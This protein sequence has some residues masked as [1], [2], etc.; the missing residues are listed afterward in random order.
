MDGRTTLNY[1]AARGRLLISLLSGFAFALFLNREI[2][3]DPIWDAVTLIYFT[4]IFL[5]GALLGAIFAFPFLT[6]LYRRLNRHPAEPRDR[7]VL[8]A[9]VNRGKACLVEEIWESRGSTLVELNKG[10]DSAIELHRH[11]L[12][13]C[14]RE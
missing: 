8:L 12:Y 7:G 11:Q 1:V 14:P 2:L 6:P 5:L 13:I 9:G 4:G 3:N 10:E